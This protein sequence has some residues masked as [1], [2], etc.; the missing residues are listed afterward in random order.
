MTEL[1]TLSTALRQG[2]AYPLAHHRPYVGG[3]NLVMQSQDQAVWIG[4]FCLIAV[5]G[6]Q[7][8]LTGPSQTFGD[9]AG[10]DNS[11]RMWLSRNDGS[12][13]LIRIDR[14][15]ADLC[16]N[17]TRSTLSLLVWFWSSGQATVAG[18]GATTSPATSGPPSTANPSVIFGP[19][20]S[21]TLVR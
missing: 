16:E 1:R 9:R 10:A 20:E 21:I 18:T 2:V 17:H 7:I 11:T 19:S 13:H 4:D 5:A 8:I 15:R 3:R 6:G 12:A 14:Q